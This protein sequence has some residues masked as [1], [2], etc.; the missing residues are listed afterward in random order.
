[1]GGAVAWAIF[2]PALCGIVEAGEGPFHM[3]PA[4]LWNGLIVYPAAAIAVFFLKR[5]IAR[6][7]VAPP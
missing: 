5:G 7:L 6:L 2:L 3:D 1:M 4:H